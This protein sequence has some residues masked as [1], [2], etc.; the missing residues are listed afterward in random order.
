MLQILTPRHSAKPDHVHQGVPQVLGISSFLCLDQCSLR[1][2]PASKCLIAL[3][4]LFKPD[5]I[6]I[7]LL[8]MTKSFQLCLLRSFSALLGP[9]IVASDAE[10]VIPEV[11]VARKSDVGAEAGASPIS[12]VWSKLSSSSTLL[13]SRS[14][15]RSSSWGNSILSIPRPGF[16]GEPNTGSRDV[17]GDD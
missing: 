9:R 16:D 17:L 13:D 6:S 14:S 1:L 7:M 3:L 5:C 15:R 8:G 4:F 2:I 10:V 12:G 11:E